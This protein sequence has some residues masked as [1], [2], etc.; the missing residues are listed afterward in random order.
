M[1]SI[2]IKLNV[3]LKITPFGQFTIEIGSMQEKSSEYKLIE[4]KKRPSII[5]S[6][7]KITSVESFEIS[8][9]GGNYRIPETTCDN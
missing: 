9:V 5:Y 3:N 6:E 2:R 1:N 4:K 8:F 7:P